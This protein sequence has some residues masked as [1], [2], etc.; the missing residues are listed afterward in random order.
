MV[1][2]VKKQMPGYQGPA[3][4]P[5]SHYVRTGTPIV[6]PADAA[7]RA[8]FPDNQEQLFMHHLFQ[9][10]YYLAERLP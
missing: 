1:R 7:Y 8:K 6:L 10:Y 2:A 4:Y 9:P 5:S 3:F